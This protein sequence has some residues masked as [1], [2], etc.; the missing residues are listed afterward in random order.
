MQKNEAIPSQEY[1]LLTL[2]AK[3]WNQLQVDIIA[4]VLHKEV[5][6]STPWLGFTI[7]GAANYISYLTEKFA[8]I[9]GTDGKTITKAR[10][11][12]LEGTPVEHCVLLTQITGSEIRQLLFFIQVKHNQIIRMYASEPDSYSQLKMTGVYP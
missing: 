5:S 3:S 6:Y 7:C 2:L 12:F 8:A 9:R 4:P 10:M 11:A 1:P